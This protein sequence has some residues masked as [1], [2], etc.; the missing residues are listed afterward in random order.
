MVIV[1]FGLPAEGVLDGGDE[2]GLVPVIVMETGHLACGIP[3]GGK[4][5]GVVVVQGQG[6]AGGIAE[7]T[8][9]E[10]PGVDGRPIAGPI[11]FLAAI[12]KQALVASSGAY[13]LGMVEELRGEDLVVGVV[14]ALVDGPTTLDPPDPGPGDGRIVFHIGKP[15]GGPVGAQVA[16]GGD[17]GLACGALVI[18][19][20]DLG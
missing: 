10:A 1:E 2:Q 20:G 9:E 7:R 13:Q 3:D 16:E 15:V 12:G 14:A 6:V 4:T 5:H 11:D 17:G 8:E 18:G 19:E